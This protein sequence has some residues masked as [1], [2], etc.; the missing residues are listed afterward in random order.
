MGILC[1]SRPRSAK[2]SR[3]GG[4][5]MKQIMIIDDDAYICDMLDEIQVGK[6]LETAYSA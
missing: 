5:N 2:G 1:R 3:T 6:L 4:E